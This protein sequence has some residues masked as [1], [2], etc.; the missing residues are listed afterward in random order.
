MTK[1]TFQTLKAQGFGNLVKQIKIKLEEPGLFIIRGPNGKGKTTAWSALAWCLYGTTLKPGSTVETWEHKRTKDWIGTMVGVSFIKGK[2]Q[3]KIIRCKDYQ[4]QI[5][6]RKGGNRLIFLKNG[7]LSR[8]KGKRDIQKLIDKILGMSFKLFTTA[9]VFPQRFP[10]FLELKGPQKKVILEES[11]NLSWI[12]QAL[13]EAKAGKEKVVSKLN[14]LQDMLE[15]K[16]SN[17]EDL[18]QILEDLAKA[19]EEFKEEKQKNLINYRAKIEEL[20]AMI[21]AK[22]IPLEKLAKVPQDIVKSLNVLKE[23]DLFKGAAQLSV[24]YRIK[25]SEETR[26]SITVKE[27]EKHKNALNKD[28]KKCPFCKHKLSNI[29]FKTHSKTLAKILSKEQEALTTIKKEL[30]ELGVKSLESD[31]H[32]KLI[33]DLEVDLTNAT[34]A[35]QEAQETNGKLTKAQTDLAIEKA[36]LNKEKERTYKDVSKPIGRKVFKIEKS[37]NKLEKKQKFYIKQLELHNWAIKD[38][39]SNTGI[40][41]VLFDQLL[42]KLNSRLA[43]YER[44]TNLGVELSVDLDSGRKNIDTII[45]KEGF[46]ISY[47]DISGGEALLINQMVA[48]AQGDILLQDTKINIRVFDEVDGALDGENTDLIATIL[49]NLGN[50]NSVFVI[51]HNKRFNITGAQEISYN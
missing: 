21:K 10:R 23:D 50:T 3:Y 26:Q 5:A 24:D 18:K 40:K 6:G 17:L 35:L 32:L 45:T 39:L 9:V 11:F 41:A 19:G 47:L 7:K 13:K 42:H 22:F 51:T 14:N 16:E 44:F 49:K 38:P 30:R 8:I 28:S 31:A 2:N 43:Y 20:R 48:L 29:D 1:I 37:I 27:A 36:N 12:S 34:T 46:P 4:N 33:D 25:L 15:A